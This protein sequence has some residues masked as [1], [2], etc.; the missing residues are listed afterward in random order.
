MRGEFAT[1]KTTQILAALNLN[2][3]L[4]RFRIIYEYCNGIEVGGAMYTFK[5]AM[6]FDKPYLAIHWDNTFQIVVMQ[7]KGFAQGAD[8]R[9]GLDAGLKILSENKGRR[10]LADLRQLGVVTQAD[11][12]WSNEDWFPRAIQAGIKH[13]ALVVPHSALARMSVNQIMSKVEGIGLVSH[14]FDSADDA[15]TWLSGQ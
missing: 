11:Q 14:Y 5:T 8:F 12:K 7:W 4:N 15:R 6:V 1:S 3:C 2:A 13:M 10:W 9:E